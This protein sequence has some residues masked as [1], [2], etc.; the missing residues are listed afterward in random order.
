MMLTESDLLAIA[1]RLTQ[2][3]GQ[4]APIGFERI[5]G[6]KNNRVYRITL[7]S[8]E[9]VI[10]KSYFTDPRD[11]RDRLAREWSFMTYAWERD[12]HGLPRPLACEPETHTGLYSFVPGRK[13][14]AGEVGIQHV[15]AAVEF[16]CAI[17]VRPRE[18]ETMPAGSEACFTL[19]EHLS[20]VDSRVRRLTTLDSVGAAGRDAE[21]FVKDRLLPV[22]AVVRERAEREG[23]A[24]GLA[25]TKEIAARDI[26]LSPSDFGFHNALVE[27]GQ[28]I[29]F[30]DFE[31]AG[32]DDPVKLVCDFFCQPEVPVPLAYHGYFLNR[33]IQGLDLDETHGARC[34]LLLDVY[35]VK[36][37]CI[38]LNDFLRSD[39]A[40][41]NFADSRSAEE[42]RAVQ[43][44]KAS[45]QIR[46]IAT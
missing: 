12:V 39:G 37:I 26:C 32:R 41:R 33:L 13:L 42:R 27:D 19:S 7:E 11:P 8:G 45:E 30:I 36:W 22:W 1:A 40:R 34:N 24:Q 38:I 21:R 3:A 31:Y 18:L 9:P 10:L 2:A 6:G 15:K 14:V 43:L 5:H 28:R 29:R 44:V 20:A 35:R 4:P 23:K 17:N 46:Q 16:V 25:L